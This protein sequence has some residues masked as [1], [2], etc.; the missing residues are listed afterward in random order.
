MPTA[1]GVWVEG[2]E[3]RERLDGGLDGV[4]VRRVDGAGGPE[5]AQA[6]GAPD[7]AGSLRYAIR[8]ALVLPT[9]PGPKN[10]PPKSPHACPMGGFWAPRRG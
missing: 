7:V 3:K 5:T 10:A 6:N 4:E 2:K 1:G 9:G 8:L